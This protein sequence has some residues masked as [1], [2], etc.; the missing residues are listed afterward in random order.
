M[1]VIL[2]YIG[3]PKKYHYISLKFLISKDADINTRANNGYNLLHTVCSTNYSDCFEII[4]YLIDV[5][6]FNIEEKEI[7]GNTPLLIAAINGN[8]WADEF[9]LER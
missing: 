4:E 3:L 8:E 5:L 2:H 6:H 7:N 9:L 1:M